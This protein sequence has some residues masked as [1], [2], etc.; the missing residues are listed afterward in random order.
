LDKFPG[1][2][3][4]VDP[5]CVDD[6]SVGAKVI[7]LQGAL[8]TVLDLGTQWTVITGAPGMGKTLGL[9]RLAQ[10]HLE[11]GKPVS[12]TPI[13]ALPALPSLPVCLLTFSWLGFS[14]IRI[15][16]VP[17]LLGNT[18]V[19]DGYVAQLQGVHPA[20]GPPTPPPKTLWIPVVVDLRLKTPED[21]VELLPR[22]ATPL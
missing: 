19:F 20:G 22:Y 15:F 4:Y 3:C 16:L 2:R 12:I 7:D 5:S 6:P 9:W 18:Q 8:E 13:A 17:L 14:W 10:R 21:L 11:V 1:P